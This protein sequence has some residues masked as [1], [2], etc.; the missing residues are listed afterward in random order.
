MFS[1]MKYAHGPSSRGIS[2]KDAKIRKFFQITCEICSDDVEFDTFRTAKEH[3]RKVHKTQFYLM[4]CGT[5]YP[6]R[7]MLLEHIQYHVDPEAHRCERCNKIFRSIEALKTH[8]KIHA[9]SRSKL[10]CGSCSKLYSTAAA[11]NAHVEQKH[12][13]D[14]SAKFHCDICR[15]A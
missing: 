4:C 1:H 11:L 10:K 9:P 2:E 6:K 13:T 15:R 14:T 7:S 5:K 3:C 12:T 8:V